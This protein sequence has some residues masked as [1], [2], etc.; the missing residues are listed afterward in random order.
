MIEK[1]NNGEAA[2]HAAW[3]DKRHAHGVD[4]V[5][6]HFVPNSFDKPITEIKHDGNE[7]G[8]ENEKLNRV[9]KAIEVIPCNCACNKK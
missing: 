1:K 9:I 5:C 2:D 7:P 6:K 8:N 3:G 4:I